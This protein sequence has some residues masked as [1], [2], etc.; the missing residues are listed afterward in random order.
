MATHKAIDHL[1]LGPVGVRAL[2]PDGHAGGGILDVGVLQRLVF[3]ATRHPSDLRIRR[4]S[5]GN[6]PL[7]PLFRRR[8]CSGLR[9]DRRYGPTRQC[10]MRWWSGVNPCL[11]PHKTA[12]V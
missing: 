2:V 9:P 12:W 5:P 6:G 4:R 7:S 8:G 3:G 10:S 11:T 1:V